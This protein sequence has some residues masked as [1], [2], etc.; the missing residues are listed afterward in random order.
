MLTKQKDEERNIIHHCLNNIINIHKQNSYS[1]SY[2]KI[3]SK[4]P[5]NLRWR[6]KNWQTIFRVPSINYIS[7]YLYCINMKTNKNRITNSRNTYKSFNHCLS[8]SSPN[9][10]PSPH[11]WILLDDRSLLNILLK[12]L[13]LELDPLLIFAD[14]W[15]APPSDVPSTGGAVGLTTVAG[16]S[17]TTCV[18][19]ASV[20]QIGHVEC[21]LNHL[22]IHSEW[23]LCLQLG[24]TLTIS[25]SS[26]ILKQTEHSVE[27]V[28]VTVSS[29][30]L[31]VKIGREAMMEGSRPERGGSEKSAVVE[32][33]MVSWRRAARRRAW[34]RRMNLAYM[35]RRVTTTTTTEREIMAVSMILLLMS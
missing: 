15:A 8:T 12:E 19:S 35:W 25:P 18:G 7:S 16:G 32:L 3:L 23:K 2:L 28:A 24:K 14:D 9:P 4:Q 10:S 5:I 6:W 22:S 30:F 17:S 29:G 1:Q 13:N 11:D 33:K 20:R 34:R 31:K 27:S 21:V 26:K